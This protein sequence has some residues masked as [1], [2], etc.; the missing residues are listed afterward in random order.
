M[1]WWRCTDHGAR[2]PAVD[3]WAVPRR[4]PKIV[5]MRIMDGDALRVD[6]LV[7]GFQLPDGK[8]WARPAGVALGPDG[9]LYFSSDSGSNGLYR[10]IRER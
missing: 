9:A 1:R 10:L 5:V 2:S 6:D 3:F 4:R 7:T 8:R